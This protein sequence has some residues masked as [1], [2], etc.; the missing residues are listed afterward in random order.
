MFFLYSICNKS[1]NLDLLFLKDFVE[2]IEGLKISQVKQ[3][4]MTLLESY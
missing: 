4:V 3:Y 2:E 1:L